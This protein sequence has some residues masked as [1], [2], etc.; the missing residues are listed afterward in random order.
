M[1][2]L[3]PS[4]ARGRRAEA[5]ACRHLERQGFV[6]ERRNVRFPVGEL[7]I[8]AR[9]GQTLCFIEVRS[10]TGGQWGDALESVTARKRQRLVQAA[11]WYL[12]A[13]R[14]APA[15]MRFDVVAI[16]WREGGSPAVELLR[17]AFDAAAW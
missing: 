9:E 2:T 8:V 7:D 4:A 12:R 17:G 16:E 1:R 15:L 5:L 13:Q 11:R 14:S 10:R 3:S 6:I